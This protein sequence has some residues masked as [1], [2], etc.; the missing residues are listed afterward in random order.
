MSSSSPINMKAIVATASGP[1]LTSVPVPKP[2]PD[3]VLVK[4]HAAALNRADLGMLKGGS[5]GSVGGA[6]T[7][8]GLE[9]AGEV[10]QIGEAVKNWQVG[11]RVM[12]AGG[13]AFAEYAIGH[14]DRIYPAPTELGYEEAAT[15]P[16]A[17][18]TE[19]DAIVTNGQLLPGQSI[20]VQ[21][22]SSGVGLMAMQIAKAFGAGLVIGTSTNEAR[23]EQLAKYGADIVV[24]SNDER[25]VKQVIDATDGNGVDLTIDHVSGP[26][27]NANMKATKV[28]GRIINVGRLGGMHGD[29]NYDLHALRRIQYLG[30]TFRTRTGKEVSSIVKKV[31]ESLLSSFTGQELQ[32]PIHQVFPLAEATDALAMMGRNEHFGKIVLRVV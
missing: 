19:H 10:A 30:V 8:L 13:N 5:H 9:W 6:G 27:G 2:G 16:I 31:T 25:W 12:A 18:Q 15:L 17:L 4:V 1:S 29:F 14:C 23:R 28:G 26:V 32:L 11:D 7:P 21:G 22:A 3:H 20:L 24:N